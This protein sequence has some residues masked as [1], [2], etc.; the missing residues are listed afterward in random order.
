MAL[1]KVGKEGVTGISNSSNATAITIDSS[2]NVGIGVTDPS[3]WS[4]GTAL[5]IG[6]K[7]NNLWGEADYAI[8][9]SQNAYYNSGWKYSHTDEATRYSQEDGQHIW[10]YAGSGSANAALTWSEAMRINASGFV[11]IGTT[12]PSYQATIFGS[13]TSTVEI[14]SGSDTGESRI[15]F[16]DPSTTGIGEIGYYHNGNSMRFNVGNAESMRLIPAPSDKGTLCIGRTT[17]IGG[18]R[19]VVDADGDNENPISVVQQHAGSS[20]EYLLLFYRGNNSD[21]YVLTGHIQNTNNATSYNTSSDYRLKTAVNYDWDAT[22]RLKQLKPARFEWISDGDSAVPVDG[23][24]AHEAAIVCPE[25]VTGTK[26]EVEVWKDG[27]ELPDGVSAG[28]NKLDSDGNTIPVMQGIDQAKLVPLLC[29]TI[30]ELE[31]RITALE[32]E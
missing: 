19:L 23:F 1:T 4:L 32:A 2:E 25:S 28:D 26:D 3:T 6:N 14:E 17:N 20:S 12:S 31:A 27:E 8:H 16:T 24:L 30:L 18:S 7:E 21:G 22:T 9:M 5:H 10:S 11:G 29:K 13:S 15:Y